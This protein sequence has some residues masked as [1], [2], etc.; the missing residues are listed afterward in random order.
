MPADTER[1]GPVDFLGRGTVGLLGRAATD[2][3]ILPPQ[4]SIDPLESKL[5][6]PR[7]PLAWWAKTDL[8]CQPTDQELATAQRGIICNH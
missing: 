7:V 3:E 2:E 1:S 8:N 6:S 4:R 5:A